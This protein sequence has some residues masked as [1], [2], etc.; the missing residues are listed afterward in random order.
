MVDKRRI[1]MA[2]RVG[3]RLGRDPVGS[4]LD[5]RRKGRN[6]IGIDSNQLMTVAG[7]GY[8]FATPAQSV[9]TPNRVVSVSLGYSTLRR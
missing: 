8:C 9:G 4:D 1:G 6:T 5:G 3:Q 2:H 7:I